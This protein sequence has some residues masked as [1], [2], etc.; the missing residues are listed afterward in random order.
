V[1]AYGSSGD[2]DGDGDEGTG[3]TDAR[4]GLTVEDALEP[5][6]ESRVLPCGGEVA[7]GEQAVVRSRHEDSSRAARRYPFLTV[8]P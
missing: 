1:C 4:P 5:D 2:G 6:G 3:T 7:A 8:I